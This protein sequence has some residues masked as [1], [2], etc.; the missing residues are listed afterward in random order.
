MAPRF[1]SSPTGSRRHSSKQLPRPA[2]ATSLL[3]GG[4]QTA[5]QYLRARLIDRFAVHVVPILL[6]G[7]S[8]LF[9]NI[10]DGPDGY[11]CVELVSSPAAA[12]FTFVRKA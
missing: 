12:H 10:E 5:Q 8:R 9:D 1:I 11:E 3:A 4:A 7:G 6:G 2:A